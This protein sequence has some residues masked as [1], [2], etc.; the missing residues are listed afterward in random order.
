MAVPTVWERRD[1]GIV[2]YAA[3]GSLLAVGA[4][5]CPRPA[6]AAFSK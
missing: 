3:A 1:Q 4:A 6:A 5:A 2:P